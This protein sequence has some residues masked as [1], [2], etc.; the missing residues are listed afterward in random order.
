MFLRTFYLSLEKSG[1]GKAEK[2]TVFKRIWTPISF[3]QNRAK[4]GKEPNETIPI[5]L[6]L[7]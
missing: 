3:G 1:Q 5:E 4:E 2:L 7:N 6:P